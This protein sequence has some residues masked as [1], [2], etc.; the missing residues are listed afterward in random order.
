MHKNDLDTPVA[1]ID[2]DIMERNIL[3]M[4]EFARK[5]GV[6]LRPHVKTHK[7]PEITRMQINAG[8][9]GITCAKLGEAEVMADLAGAK[10]IFIANLIVGKE[11]IQR[12]L[13]LAER[14]KISLGVDSVEAAEPLSDAAVKRNLKIPVLIKVDVGQ[15]RTGVKYGEPSVQFA[16]KLESMKGLELEGIYTHEGHV[17]GA[18]GFEEVQK[19]AIESGERIVKTAEMIKAAGIEVKT[20]SVGATPTAEI[21][22]KIPGVTE[23]RPG[24]YVF[25][26]YF[27]IKLG[28]AKEQ[29]CAFTV[30]AT[31]ISVPAPDRAV[32]DAGTKSFFSDKSKDFGVYGLVKGRP[33]LKL[34][35]AYE[36]HGVIKIESPSEKLKVG[37]KLE[38]IPNHV[39][40][41]VN[42]FD[43]LIGIRKDMVTSTWNILARGKLK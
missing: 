3:E 13:N 9:S 35:R 28:V 4:A 12:L 20:V 11:K 27:Q 8:A 6:S 43:E 19:I 36:E 17:Y 10:D 14:I 16:K 31:V 38:V 24:T 21:T 1:I 37:D 41:A 26:D 22:P 5:I 29:D 18:S 42:L 15:E 25:D 23:M 2:L 39:C 34:A 7:T 33:N 30:L 32:I 40:P